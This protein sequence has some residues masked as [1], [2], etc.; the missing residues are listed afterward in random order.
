M[1]AENTVAMRLKSFADRLQ[2]CVAG[3]SNCCFDT[4][5]G[6]GV[7]GPSLEVGRRI[8]SVKN[9]ERRYY[10]RPVPTSLRLSEQKLARSKSGA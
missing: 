10:T 1:Y 8:D 6:V 9:Q 4:L 3:R 7:N 2:L 5:V